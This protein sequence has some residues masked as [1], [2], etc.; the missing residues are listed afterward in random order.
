VGL[1]AP[2]PCP[3]SQQ[4]VFGQFGVEH[5][6]DK[7]TAIQPSIKAEASLTSLDSHSIFLFS[8]ADFLH[9]GDLQYCIVDLYNLIF[10]E[11]LQIKN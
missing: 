5:D 2:R 6:E 11:I 9:S 8:H 3:R 10:T 4:I 1:Q 7:L